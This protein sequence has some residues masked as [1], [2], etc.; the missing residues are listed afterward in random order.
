[1]KIKAIRYAW[2]LHYT[3]SGKTY[4]RMFLVMRFIEIGK[5]LKS[6]KIAV[7]KENWANEFFL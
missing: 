3:I 5:K 2:F 1:M 6:L 4:C 7:L